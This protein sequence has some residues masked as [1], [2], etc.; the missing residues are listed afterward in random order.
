MYNFCIYGTKFSVKCN[1]MNND[2]DDMEL[3][4]FSQYHIMQNYS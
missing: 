2:D 4:F 3:L 1:V